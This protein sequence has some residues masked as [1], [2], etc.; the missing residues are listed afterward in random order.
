MGKPGPIP[1]LYINIRLFQSLK[2]KL[3]YRQL[4]GKKENSKIL[5]ISNQ[6]KDTLDDFIDNSY[7][8]FPDWVG[9][10]DMRTCNL[11]NSKANSADLLEKN[12]L[13]KDVSNKSL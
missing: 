6:Y 9:L 12:Y 4:G 7:L 3:S 5:V 13:D 10:I 8:E 11:P 1:P 2:N